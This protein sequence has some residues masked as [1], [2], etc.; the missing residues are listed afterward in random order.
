MK[1]SVAYLTG[2][3]NPRLEWFADSLHRQVL[4]GDEIELLVIDSLLWENEG[5]RS[6]QVRAIVNDRFPLVHVPP[7]PN[8][9][10]G[11]S[12]LTKQDWWAA[13]NTRNTAMCECSHEWLA[14]ADDLS[15][16]MP[17]WLDGV[18]RA[19]NK[20]YVLLGA[21]AKAHDMVVTDGKL[22]SHHVHDLD[23]RL[24]HTSGG[25]RIEVDGAW[26]CGCSFAAP[27]E[28]FLEVNGMD[29]AADSL[30]S[31]DYLLG[32][33]L[34]KAGR[35]FIYDPGVYT[36]EDR[37]AHFEPGNVL[38]R[39]DYTVSGAP[40]KD[41]SHWILRTVREGGK[42]SLGTPDLRELRALRKQGLPYPVPGKPDHH[43]YTGIPLNELKPS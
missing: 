34:Q 17:G 43:I 19:M 31:E 40:D 6:A 5:L 11:P 12:K 3:N 26:L 41:F 32:I 36:V 9:W 22:V 10:Q 13:S 38:L 16:V 15:V 2:R 20:G 35:R 8:V 4:K 21:Y 29:E 33:R 23:H 39:S 24:R 18:R 1:L 28:W 14:F 30:S 37:L 25:K 42:R 27:L 7:K